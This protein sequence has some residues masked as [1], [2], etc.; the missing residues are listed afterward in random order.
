MTVLQTTNFRGSSSPELSELQAAAVRHDGGPLLVLGG[1]GTGKTHVLERRW[2]ALAGSGSLRSHRVLLL[3]TNRAYAMEARDRLVWALPDPATIEVPVYTW[4]ALAYH[5]VSRY[6]PRLGYREPPVLLTGPEQWGLVRELL[7]AE[8]PADWPRWA[9]RLTDRGFVDEVADFCLRVGQRLMPDED[10]EALARHRPDWLEVV[11]FRSR[12]REHLQTEA[13]LDYA[14]LIA[15]A[16]RLLDENDDVRGALRRRFPHVLVDDGQEM[17]L[18]HRELLKRLETSNLVVAADPDAGI[19]TFRGAEP[20]W[21]FGF[22]HWFGPHETVT[23]DR[24]FRLGAPLAPSAIRL[25]EHNGPADHRLGAAAIHETA[26]ECR[27]YPSIAEEVEAIAREL[28]H[29][30]LA[31]GVAWDDMAVLVSQPVYLLGPLQQALDRWEVPYQ[32]M[33]GDRPL[34]SEP[35]VA[36]FLD[37]V[38]VAL[39][40]E[41]WEERLPGLLTSPLVGLGYPERRRLE[42][43]A[44]QQRTTLAALVVAAAETTELRALC[45]LVCE[46]QERADECFWQVWSAS[47]HYRELARA[48]LVDEDDP[49]NAAV[50]AL[51]AFGHALGRF[52]ERRHGRG[53]IFEF[54][55]GAAR[56]DFGA[57][58]WLPPGRSPAG[59][60][61]IVS[62]HGARGRQWH[63]VVVAGCLDAWIP[64]GRRAQGLFDPFSLEIEEAADR[65]VEAI[66]DDR[67]TFYVA[68]TRA[69]ARTLFTVSP[70]PSG[71]GQ[72]SRFLLELAGEGPANGPV[73]ELPPLTF[74]ELRARLRRTLDHPGSTSAT[75]LAALIAL[76]EVPGTDPRSWYGRWGW[77]AGAVPLAERGNFKTSYSRLSAY[78]NCPLQYV[79]Q[80]VLGLDPTTTHSMKFGTWMH[81][82]FEAV[83]KGRLL[84]PAA[85]LAEYRRLFDERVFPNA[86]VAR[87]F[88]RDGEKMLEA[89][90]TYEVTPRTVLA[91]Y[92]FLFE[93]AGAML[94]GR[95]DRVD[96]IGNNLV[97][98]DYK[99]AKW[100]ASPQEAQES[101]QL[102]IYHLAATQDE[103]LRAL[104]APQAA[105]LTYPG[106]TFPDGQPIA[107]VQNAEQAQT[108]IE[109]LPDLI[110]SVLDETF[111]PSLDADC[112]WC[113]MKP[114]CPLWPEGSEVG[115][116]KAVGP[117]GQGVRS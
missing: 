40:A 23:L 114:L 79:L 85:L 117:E 24:S 66:A 92:P 36:G 55:S 73:R 116:A 18:A 44:W 77:T 38:R 29:A 28:R 19:E 90:W 48:A 17:S 82:L 89:F 16:V 2:L 25:I 98:T 5:L 69:T 67:R 43:L 50:D 11:R 62:F 106:A 57:D 76:A 84:T 41:G 78:Q 46:Y 10:L 71:R 111:A 6:H 94:R 54:L 49:A 110:A 100:A 74:P 12:Y 83:H 34:A 65:E 31:D 9:E 53:T 32:P 108:V 13:R 70:G 80:S 88:R 37:L 107:R 104:G 93:H 14:G 4:H 101:L 96:R 113:Q 47:R 51:V 115:G 63:T 95:I 72:P 56:A 1:P 112:M 58:P 109:R 27:L 52:V 26:F 21:L 20:D 45:G 64:K 105:R 60:I 61:A 35:A 97:L 39:R 87:Q 91:E 68:A 99:T 33:A 86:T 103:E 3:C 42:R 81:A 7:A 59:R 15:T 102:A 75:R 8:H 30:H 22:G